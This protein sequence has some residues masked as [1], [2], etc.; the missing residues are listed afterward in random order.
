VWVARLGARAEV[1]TS[2]P[3]PLYLRNPDAQPQAGY[4][5]PRR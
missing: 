1:A 5:L 3:R 2:P 4:K